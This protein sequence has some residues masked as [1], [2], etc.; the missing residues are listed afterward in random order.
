MILPGQTLGGASDG[1]QRRFI[2]T[3]N[4]DPY[5]DYQKEINVQPNQIQGQQN[6][7]QGQND[8]N[9][10][11]FNSDPNPNNIVDPTGQNTDFGNNDNQSQNQ[12]Q[13]APTLNDIMNMTPGELGSLFGEDVKGFT[14]EEFLDK[15]GMYIPAYDPTQEEFRKEE[16][17]LTA[18][19]MRDEMA[20]GKERIASQFRSMSSNFNQGQ[21]QD[22][23]I[24]SASNQFD[25]S[26][27]RKKQDIRGI[28]EG[29]YSDIMETLRFLGEQGAFDEAT[30]GS[31]KPK[32]PEEV[33]E[34][35]NNAWDDGATTGEIKYDE[36]GEP[37]IWTGSYWRS[38]RDTGGRG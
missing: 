5:G 27:I 1:K 24:D 38:Q 10:S 16:Y 15:Y 28:Q 29:Y 6:Q 35:V 14:E 13:N 8:I 25:L 21:I 18:S 17:N 37:W 23:L 31:T 22:K 11:M 19:G 20:I 4:D 7:I 3:F 33:D 32:S 36:Y 30:Y 26:N 2:S 12:N 34:L 9:Y